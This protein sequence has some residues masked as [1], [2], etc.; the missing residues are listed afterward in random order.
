LNPSVPMQ[1]ARILFVDPEPASQDAIRQSL[2]SPE[3]PWEIEFVCDGAAALQALEYS[4]FDV[5]VTSSAMTAEF[6]APLLEHARVHHPQTL[7]FVMSASG[8]DEAGPSYAGTA[9]QLVPGFGEGRSDLRTNLTKALQLRDLLSDAA[10]KEVISRIEFLPS[11]PASYRQMLDLLNSETSTLE[12]VGALIER[13]PAICSKL[14]QMVNSAFF[15]LG[16]RVSNAVRAVSLLGLE[17]VKAL[18]LSAGVYSQIPPGAASKQDIDWLWKHSIR[19][20]RMSQKVAMAL[21]TGSAIIVDDSF[22]SGLLHDLGMLILM[23]ECADD[24]RTIT[25][26]AAQERT[27][28]CIAER[29]VLGCTHAEVGAYLLGIWGLPHNIVEAVAWHHHPSTSAVAEPSALLA[30]HIADCVQTGCDPLRDGDRP[31]I[32]QT[33]VTRCGYA[34]ATGK[35]VDSCRE[36]NLGL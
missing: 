18:V 28:T 33:F 31:I 25:K 36:L 24:F 12:N 29:K 1:P 27:A 15:G 9:H 32:D 10:L 11:A 14:L 4:S 26:V 8:G 17:V 22:V 5:I 2:H 13:D 6:G 20:S 35:L 19:V 16:C 30:V 34:G 3:T 21:G 23:C 7:R